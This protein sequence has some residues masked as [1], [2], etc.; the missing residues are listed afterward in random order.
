MNQYSKI[1]SDIYGAEVELGR[2]LL[3]GLRVLAGYRFQYYRDGT[4]LHE[5][6][7]SAV[8]PFDLTSTRHTVTLGVTLTSALLEKK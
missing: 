6:V 1:E 3:E 5:S 4:N 8:V 2:W 7:Q